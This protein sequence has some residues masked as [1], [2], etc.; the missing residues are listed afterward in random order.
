MKKLFA[1]IFSFLL[2]GPLFAQTLK[3]LPRQT[4]KWPVVISVLKQNISLPFDRM[5]AITGTRPLNPG[6]SVGTQYTYRQG[7]KTQLYQTGQTGLFL[8]KNN[9]NGIFLGTDVG[10]KITLAKTGLYTEYQI[11]LNYLHCFLP[12]NSYKL[13][14]LGEYEPAK[15]GGNGSALVTASISLGFEKENRFI[16]VSPFIK[17]QPAVQFFY[18]PGLPVIP[19]S[20]L[21]VGVKINSHFNNQ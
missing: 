5:V 12:G 8:N 2:Q 17:Y 4:Q 11:G 14:N 7:R 13:N 21:H 6:F 9:G 18:N 1:L 10:Y 16:K 19:Q 20:Y 15:N 3:T